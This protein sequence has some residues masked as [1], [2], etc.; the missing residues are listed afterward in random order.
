MGGFFMLGSFL[1]RL[2]ALADKSALVLIVPA[3][4]IAYL[5]DEAM[6]L[7]L[8]QWLVFAPILAGVAIHISRIVFPQVHLTSYLQKAETGNVAAGL[9]ASAIIVFVA[10][11]VMALVVWTKA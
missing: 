5:I 2:A 9:V 6:A 11:I 7:T 10:A 8:V 3:L 4:I 1:K